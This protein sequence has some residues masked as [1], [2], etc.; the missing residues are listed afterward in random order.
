MNQEISATIE[1]CDQEAVIF[2]VQFKDCSFRLHKIVDPNVASVFI[3]AKSYEAMSNPA[4]Q[5][6]THFLSRDRLAICAAFDITLTVAVGPLAAGGYTLAARHK[7]TTNAGTAFGGFEVRISKRE[8]DA[9]VDA[10]LLALVRSCKIQF[11]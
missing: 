9:L 6:L 10:L 11:R 5:L 8:W 3:P 2:N 4:S 1:Q 7:F